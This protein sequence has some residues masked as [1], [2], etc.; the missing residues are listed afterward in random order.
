MK[1]SKRFL[2]IVLMLAM[3][4][5][6]FTVMAFAGDEPNGGT[7]DA[8]EYCVYIKVIGSESG[9]NG[10][11]AIND[12]KYT[13]ES[14][15]KVNFNSLTALNQAYLSVLCASEYKATVS[16]DKQGL[17]LSDN[18]GNLNVDFNGA[19]ITVKFEN[20]TSGETPT[21]PS[22][23]KHNVYVV[24]DGNGTGTVTS[25]NTKVGNVVELGDSETKTLTA[26]PNE[27]CTVSW[28]LDNGQTAG[29]PSSASEN[30]ASIE[31][32]ASELKGTNAL[33]TITFSKK[34]AGSTTEEHTL[35]VS[36]ERHGQI[37]L[38]DGDLEKSDSK[39][40]KKG[41]KFSV[42]VAADKGYKFVKW[43]ASGIS[44]S[45]DQVKTEKLELTMPDAEVKLT[46][47]FERDDY[48]YG[49]DKL[50]IDIYNP[51]R[52]TVKF[53]NDSDVDN[54][55]YFWLEDGKTYTI[56][57]TADSGYTAY[58]YYNGVWDYGRSF[59]F[60]M[61]EDC[62]TLYV[63]FVRDGYRPSYDDDSHTLTIDITGEKHGTVKRGT[64]KLYDGYTM[65]LDK[66]DTRTFKATPDK[67]YVAVWTFRGESYVGNEFTVKMGSKNATLYIEFMDEDDYRLWN[68]PFRDVSERDW[69][70][71][72]VAYVYANGYMEGVSST[73]FAP[74]QNTTRAQIV[75]ILW[76][77]TGEPRAMKSNKFSDVSSAAYYDKAVSWAV[78]AGVVNGFDAKTFKPND[79]VTREQLA[80]ILYRYAEYMN[81]STRGASNLTKY[82]D[83]YQIG[84]WA[85]DAMAW[86]NYHGLINGVSYTR[87]DP[88]GLATRAQ[89]AA[90]LHRFAVEFGN[91]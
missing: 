50:T 79:Y 46:A 85:R 44:L 53:L 56:Y 54:G 33:L 1:T 90:I 55:D 8:E 27:G 66:N 43:I 82:D 2:S 48:Y 72:D 28:K 39:T 30:A 83:Y 40:L 3:L 65:S 18:G 4:V 5:S 71:S 19:T 51:T 67:G 61:D 16:V 70:Y 11:A 41:D 75:T 42:D 21:Q 74:Y 69:F 59:K 84:T 17:S 68:L 91:Y 49:D 45:N 15:E 25:D 58:W 36:A 9:A 57:A 31:L 63:E 10:Y 35:T 80:A 87:I 26:T 86:A 13:S 52:G 20:K 37:R 78:E 64:T 77:L 12:T 81:L 32:K 22:T 89:V 34:D 23:T 73:K 38:N 47:K 76:R 29:T 14:K 88:K 7:A 62:N 24:I 6:M 60:K